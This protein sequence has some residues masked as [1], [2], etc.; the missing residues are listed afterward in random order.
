[1]DNQILKARVAYALA[2]SLGRKCSL[3]TQSGDLYTGFLFSFNTRTIV[4]KEVSRHGENL[5]QISLPFANIVMTSIESVKP[6]DKFK[7]DKQISKGKQADRELVAWVGEDAP[8][9]MNL[10]SSGNWDQ[11]AVN[12][13]KFGVISTYD[14]KYYTTE[15]DTTGLTQE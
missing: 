10:G 15:L 1:M 7:T 3:T 6:I 5:P 9:N 8:G 13:D 12:E 11:F 14:D 4:L 2:H